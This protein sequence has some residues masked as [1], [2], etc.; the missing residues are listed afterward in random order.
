MVS[1]NNQSDEFTELMSKLQATDP[2][3]RFKTVES[4][5]G[6]IANGDIQKDRDYFAE[7]QQFEKNLISTIFMYSACQ[8]LA[9]F[10]RKERDA[11]RLSKTY[12]MIYYYQPDMEY[13]GSILKSRRIG[14]ITDL[15]DKYKDDQVLYL[16][17]VVKY[18]KYAVSD[19]L[20]D[21]YI[22]NQS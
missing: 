12:A 2:K 5:F 20:N 1:N 6:K 19:M 3:L 9:D 4:Y 14:V 18:A 10:Y 11:E 15:Y 16:R 7:F 21:D 8:L 22:N 13:Y 17:K